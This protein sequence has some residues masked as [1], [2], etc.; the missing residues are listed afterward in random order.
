ML[1]PGVDCTG[2]D[3]V[4]GA[5]LLDA[6]QPLHLG[7]VEHLHLGRGQ[8]HIAVDRVANRRHGPSLA[9]RYWMRTGNGGVS[10]ETP[11]GNG[12]RVTNEV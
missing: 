7:C 10:P 6:A 8:P 5:E 3:Q 9:A 1:E 11:S 2:I 12:F 4:G